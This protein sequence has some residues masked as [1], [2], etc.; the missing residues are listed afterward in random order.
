[1]QDRGTRHPR[2]RD[3]QNNKHRREP[4]TI[5]AW[6]MGVADQG[7]HSILPKAWCAYNKNTA[8]IRPRPRNILPEV[9]RSAQIERSRRTQSFPFYLATRSRRVDSLASFRL[10]R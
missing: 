8:Y 4:P 6:G 10:A 7:L 1:M 3:C 2:N 5:A 9:E